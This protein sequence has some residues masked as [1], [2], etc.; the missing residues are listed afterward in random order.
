MAST[1]RTT[2]FADLSRRQAVLILTA[3]TIALVWCLCAAFAPQ[4]PYQPV[5]GNGS[6]LHLYR[7]IVECVHAGEDYYE[8]A[9]RE[10]RAVGYPTGSIFNWRPPLYA[11]LIGALP[12]PTWAQAILTILAG[13]VILLAGRAMQREGGIGRVA[14]GIFPLIG[15]LGWCIDG[16]AFLSQEL[17]AGILICLSIC[18]YASDRWHIG[19]AVG[20]LA[21]FFRELALPYCLIALF[22]SWRQQRRQEIAGWLIGLGLY[23]LYMVLHIVAV[24]AQILPGD[25]LHA[26]WIQF[27]GAAFLLATC[28][29]NAYLF[30]LPLWA[31]ALYLPLA[32]L[33]LAGWRGWVG[34]RFALTAGAY[35]AAFAVVGQP[36]NDYWGLLMAPLL[37]CGCAAAPEALRDLFLAVEIRLRLSKVETTGHLTEANP[38]RTL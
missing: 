6:D 21:L 16:D 14:A 35:V 1:S 5:V 3:T 7:R 37:A 18:A 23:C 29:M 24:V 15:A 22:L 30:K 34:S 9:G 31:S 32:L 10:M 36:F 4:T 26:S 2:R 38:W 28:R 12:S 20:L 11:W 19:L 33:G 17:W 13:L 27:G 25:R 8:A